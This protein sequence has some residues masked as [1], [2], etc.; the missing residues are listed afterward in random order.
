MFHVRCKKKTSECNLV[1][2]KEKRESLQDDEQKGRF[3]SSRTE[4]YTEIIQKCLAED[5][6][7]NV[8]ML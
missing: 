3:S 1:E 7:L 8:R 4:E 2:F 5:R 6:T